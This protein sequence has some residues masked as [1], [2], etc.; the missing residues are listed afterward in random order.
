MQLDL[1]AMRFTT[2]LPMFSS[3]FPDDLAC[4]VDGLSVDWTD[5]DLYAFPP[6]RLVPKVL[7]RL[8]QFPCRMMLVASLRWNRAWMTTL[9]QRTTEL[10]RQLPLTSNLLTQPGSG[11]RH[12]DPARLNLHILRL[13][14]G[15][16]HPVASQIV[17][18]PDVT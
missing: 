7:L 5:K 1:F 11:I 8:A 13:Y 18:M 3:P 12:S 2:R 17:R 15:P 16:L 14:G 10:P 9:L 6:A 4:G